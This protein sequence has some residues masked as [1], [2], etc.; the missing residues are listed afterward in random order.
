M[1]PA[2]AVFDID[3]PPGVAFIRSLGRAGVPVVAMSSRRTEAGRYSRYHGELRSCPPLKRT[4]EFVD[5]LSR[6]SSSG[7]RSISSRRRPTTSASAS[8]RRIEKLGGDASRRRA[9]RPDGLRTCLFKDRFA[10]AMA[11]VG[12][13]TPA[14]GDPGHGR[15]RRRR[16]AAEI[17]YP[18][19]LKPRT[20]AGIGTTR[21]IGRRAPPRSWP[22]GSGRTASPDGNTSVTAPRPGPRPADRAALPRARDG[23]RGQRVGL[24]RPRRRGAGAVATAARSASRRGA[25]GSARCS[26]RSRTSRSRMR[27]STP[28]GSVLGSGIFELEVLVD[29]STGE[30]WAVDLNPRGFGQM[31]LDMA[32]GNDLPVLL[33][34]LRHG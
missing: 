3:L 21:G 2:V 17:G 14:D 33:V 24:P 5:W 15:P 23:R 32:L 22:R 20:H 9:A 26:S 12:F 34:P 25:S 19:V 4:D 7:D 1:S 30:Y 18:V 6:A 8:P 13:P 27:P 16:S 10:V 11:N 28:S 31:S 29:R